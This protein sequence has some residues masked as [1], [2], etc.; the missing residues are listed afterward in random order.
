[1]TAEIRQ[2]HTF[3]ND[4]DELDVITIDTRPAVSHVYTSKYFGFD[5]AGPGWKSLS[6]I[7]AVL[8]TSILPS[9]GARCECLEGDLTIRGVTRKENLTVEVM[10]SV[11]RPL[12]EMQAGA[13]RNKFRF[14]ART[15]RGRQWN[16]R[17][18]FVHIALIQ[19]L[20]YTIMQQRMS[21]REAPAS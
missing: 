3:S 12:V 8:L 7:T 16:V 4:W 10:S 9:R 2:L 5:P 17:R 18:K 13:A 20:R 6:F 21:R 1:V 15:T 11:D 19:L 14:G